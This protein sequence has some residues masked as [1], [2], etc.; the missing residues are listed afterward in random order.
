VLPLLF[1][2]GFYLTYKS[3]FE[4]RYG[5]FVTLGELLLCFMLLAYGI[6]ILVSGYKRIFL[7]PK[8]STFANTID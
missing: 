6:S 7:K 5:W 8:E 4:S 3:L 2:G 1:V